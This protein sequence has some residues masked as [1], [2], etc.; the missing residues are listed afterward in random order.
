MTQILFIFRPEDGS[1]PSNSTAIASPSSTDGQADVLNE[2]WAPSPNSWLLRMPKSDIL[3]EASV[4]VDVWSEDG[5]Y[6][7]SLLYQKVLARMGATVST[8]LYYT[9]S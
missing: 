5:Q 6:N 8:I 2:A 3:K 7:R 1:S 4:F 9:V